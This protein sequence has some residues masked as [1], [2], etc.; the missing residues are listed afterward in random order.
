MHDQRTFLEAIRLDPDDDLLRLAFADWLDE[1]GKA[2]WASVIRQQIAHQRRDPDGL[3]ELSV[4]GLPGPAFFC[5]DAGRPDVDRLRDEMGYPHPFDYFHLSRGLVGRLEMDAATFL[6]VGPELA[7]WGGPMPRLRLLGSDDE[8]A[9]LAGCQAL[10]AV[11]DLHLPERTG[12]AALEALLGSPRLRGGGGL[13]GLSL[14]PAKA[15]Q[16]RA[17]DD[18]R[19]AFAGCAWTGPS[20]AT[21]AWRSW[22]AAPPGCRCWKRCR[23]SGAASPGRRYCPWLA[24][25]RGR[26]CATCRCPTT[27]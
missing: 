24:S 7:A 5:W 25:P 27:A 8:L 13:E 9:D 14:A 15:G 18:R 1:H 3:D 10:S 4:W 6:R 20:S 23:S 22:R 17:G 2:L 19:P 21:P 11:R 26:A 12:D 16:V